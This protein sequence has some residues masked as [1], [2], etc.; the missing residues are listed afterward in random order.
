M[1]VGACSVHTKTCQCSNQ[2]HIVAESGLESVVN[3]DQLQTLD[4]PEVLYNSGGLAR[5]IPAWSLNVLLPAP[6]SVCNVTSH[7]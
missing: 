5:T 6:V 3:L 7:L 1:Y 2:V 4:L